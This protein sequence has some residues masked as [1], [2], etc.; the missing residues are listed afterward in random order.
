[1]LFCIFRP[2]NILTGRFLVQLPVD[3]GRTI[4]FRNRRRII[5]RGP[6]HVR[7]LLVQGQGVEHGVRIS[8]QHCQGRLNPEFHL[9]GTLVR[10]VRTVFQPA[11]SPRVD[12]VVCRRYLLCHVF[13]LCISKSFF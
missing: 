4:R 1:M 13:H 6:E 11:C 8:A 7:S 5:G 9:H 2:N 10:L 3:A 12:P